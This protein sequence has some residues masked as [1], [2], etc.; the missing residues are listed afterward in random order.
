M[1]CSASETLNNIEIKHPGENTYLKNQI[2]TA[3]SVSI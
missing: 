3:E 2:I 1:E